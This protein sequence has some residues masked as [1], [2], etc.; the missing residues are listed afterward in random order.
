[1]PVSIII[2]IEDKELRREAIKMQKYNYL[3]EETQDIMDYLLGNYDV[4][5]IEDFDQDDLSDL[6][7]NLWT[8][9]SVTGNASGSYTFNESEAEE[10]L[11]YNRDLLV[12]ALK[13]FAVPSYEL[14]YNYIDD[15]EAEDVLVRCYVLP[16]AIEAAVENIKEGNY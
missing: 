10:H 15:P 2:I 6:Q 7:D 13:E 16:Q 12:E 11:L 1:M 8:E 4:K 14:L 5:T 9:D 3:K